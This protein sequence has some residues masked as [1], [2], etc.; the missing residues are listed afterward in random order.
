[1]SAVEQGNRRKRRRKLKAAEDATGKRSL[2][3]LSMKH[4]A[5]AVLSWHCNGYVLDGERLGRETF[6]KKIG[7]TLGQ[8]DKLID[9]VHR[10]FVKQFED[11]EQ[12]KQQV[13]SMAATLYHQLREDRARAV[14]HCDHLNRLSRRFVEEL[15]NV[16]L[17][18]DAQFTETNTRKSKIDTCMRHI[19]SLGAL[20]SES[21]RIMCQTS[22]SLKEYLKMFTN[23]KSGS[24]P[25]PNIFVEV[26]QNG[27]QQPVQYVD[28]IRIIESKCVSN[29][30]SQD[31]QLI[32]QGPRN[33]NHGFE[34]LEEHRDA[35]H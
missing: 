17:M 9:E 21:V 18:S 7:I 5:E 26:H 19:R 16:M 4:K 30:P 25:M 32:N 20:Q 28:A 34:E 10:N 23:D 31:N 11:S 6:A 12:V 27:G 15:N 24:L 33:P 14:I 22:S 3:Q 35:K 2:D 8:L 29:L 1:M 13:F